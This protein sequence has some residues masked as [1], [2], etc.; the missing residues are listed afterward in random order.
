[1]G[2][3]RNEI[4]RATGTNEELVSV[5]MQNEN[6]PKVILANYNCLWAKYRIFFKFVQER[7]KSTKVV[8]IFDESHHFKGGKSFTSAVKSVYLFLQI[9]GSFVWNTY[10]SEV[11][12]LVHQFKV[13]LPYMD[14]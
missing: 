6:P 3:K 13:L 1:M 14:R 4:Y 2:I 9:I 8:T 11:D 12:D 5:L 10:A 7:T